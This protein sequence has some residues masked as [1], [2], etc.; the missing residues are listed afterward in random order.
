MFDQSLKEG[1]KEDGDVSGPDDLDT[2]QVPM[3][4][5]NSNPI[6]SSSSPHVPPSSSATSASS[7]TSS[8]SGNVIKNTVLDPQFLKHYGADIL[9]GPV[10]LRNHLDMSGHS[11]LITLTSPQLLKTKTR[12]FLVHMKAMSAAPTNTVL[13]DKVRHPFTCFRAHKSC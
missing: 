3:S 4:A 12:S 9:C 2:G 1:G 5:V 13:S 8:S 6:S 11:G 7:S 10:D